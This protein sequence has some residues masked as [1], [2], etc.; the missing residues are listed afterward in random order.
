GGRPNPPVA[1]RIYWASTE[2]AVAAILLIGGGLGALQT[3]A[4]SAGL[5]FAI[6]ILLMIYSLQKALMTDYATLNRSPERI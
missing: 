4:I 5:P 3:A 1:Q 2:G 6:L